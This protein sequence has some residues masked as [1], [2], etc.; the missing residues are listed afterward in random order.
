MKISIITIVYNDYT[1]LKRTRRSVLEQIQKPFE[2]IVVDGKSPDN[3]LKALTFFEEKPEIVI[4]EQD[5]GIYHAMNKGVRLASGDFVI[6]LNAGDTFFTN[7]TLKDLMS[8]TLD[9]KTVYFGNFFLIRPP[10]LGKTTEPRELTFF[11]SLPFNHQSCLTPLNLLIENPFDEQ[12]RILGDLKFYKK[13]FQNKIPFVHL[14]I[15]I[16]KYTMDGIS[17]IPSFH[18]LKEVWLLNRDSSLYKKILFSIKYA[19][20]YVLHRL[21]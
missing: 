2:H 21:V 10:H 8:R 9:P 17:S 4:S 7:R 1:G 6:F 15:V 16:A 13:L 11:D 12:L 20:K 14:D 3:T 19:V 18:Y 5:K